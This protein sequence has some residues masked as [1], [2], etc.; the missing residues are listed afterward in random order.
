MNVGEMQR[1]L[2]VGAEQDKDHRFF[3]LYHLLYDEDW[4]LLAHDYVAQNAGSVTAGCDGVVMDYFDDDLW[5]NLQRIATDLRSG[6]FEPHPVR[7]VHI[8]KRNGKLRPL[9]IPT[10]RDRI[11]QEALRM[12][13]EPIFE[14]DFVQTSYGFRPNRCTLDA[15]QRI[16]WAAR[17]PR[18]YFWVI[19]GDIASYFDTIHHRKLME[20]LRR[21][22]A[23]D[24]VL[25]LVWWFLR[26]GVMERNVLR[27][28]TEGT[29]QGGIISP[30]LANV[31]LHELDKY[32]ERYTALSRNEKGKR[33]RQG[34]GN[35]VHVRYADDFVVLGNGNRAEA[36]AL[37]QELIEFLRD[38]LHLTL[39][40][41]KT[42]ITH[43]D[44]GFE[45][46]GFRFRRGR[47]SKGTVTKCLVPPRAARAHLDKLRATTAPNTSPDSVVAKFRALD[48]IIGGWCR[49]YE[50]CGNVGVAFARLA[51]RTYWLVGHWLGRKFKKRMWR[52]IKPYWQGQCFAV[53]QTRLRLHSEYKR[54]RP[55]AGAFSK[56]NPYT[57][58]ERINREEILGQVHF[59]TG[60]EDRPG[61]A[62]L[63][64]LVSRRDG[65]VCFDCKR[66]VTEST[67]QLHH[68]REV[69]YFKRPV[70][71]NT[72]DNTVLLCIPCHK[73]RT[74]ERRQQLES[75]MR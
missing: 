68:L 1:K 23:D 58:Q 13:L 34:L 3:D 15:V 67:S 4:L 56:P 7:R 39:S 65:Y 5:G 75:R 43:L 33:R 24:K 71:A 19:E 16:L 8:R 69:R 22:V 32:M 42:T 55:A 28:T 41:E 2:S 26:A 74:R 18:K 61:Q 45:F 73:K 49:Y 31:Y 38:R 36:E 53:G 72:A 20:L 66:P 62:D 9:G 47:G 10:V 25:D 35:F 64:L 50:T 59:W 11:V 46:L 63:K 14:A 40:Q 70:D 60:L 48:R 29:P 52:A 51:H 6:A 27:A 21:R 17:E 12:V 44:D 54:Q 57:T 37:K 30:L